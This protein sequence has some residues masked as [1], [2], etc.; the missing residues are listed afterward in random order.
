MKIKVLLMI[1]IKH[2]RVRKLVVTQKTKNDAS[3]T[4]CKFSHWP[5]LKKNKQTTKWQ[6]LEVTGFTKIEIIW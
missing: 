1:H 3:I 2:T 4:G 5:Q 6:T